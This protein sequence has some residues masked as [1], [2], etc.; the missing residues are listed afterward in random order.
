MAPPSHHSTATPRLGGAGPIALRYPR[1]ALPA[2]AR[3]RLGLRAAVAA[4]LALAGL[5]L[6]LPSTPT[7]DPWAWLIWGREI[8][9]GHL[10]TLTGPSWKPLPVLVTT[11]FSV[12]GAA[13]P[14]LW[15]VVARAGALLSLVLAFRVGRRLGGTLAGAV[16]A[17]AL[18]LVHFYARAAALGDSEGLLV[19]SGLLAVE[20]HLRGRRR[21]A[22]LAL[23]AMG[24]LRPEAWLFLGVYGLWLWRVEPARRPLIAGLAV[25]LPA[26][27]LGPELWGSGNALRASS[28]AQEIVPGSPAA[29]EHPLEALLERALPAVLLPVGVAAAGALAHAVWTRRSRAGSPAVLGL[30]AV[31]LAWYAEVAVMTQVGYSGN[32]RYLMAPSAI[33]CVL[34]GIGF[35]ALVATTGARWGRRAGWAL[36]V[37]LLAVTAPYA[38]SEANQ[39]RVDGLA[40]AAEARLNDALSR[41][42]DLAGGRTGVLSCGR[43]TTGNLQVTPLAWDL[44]VNIDR[45]GYVAPRRAVAFVARPARDGTGAPV[46]RAGGGGFSLLGTV[47]AWHV[48]ARCGSPASREH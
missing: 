30:G 40:V 20:L 34:G 44:R 45:V 8:A 12:A 11:A 46:A 25:A 14:A 43:P 5:S 3:P 48:L 27:W 22:L 24:L 7:Y 13:A 9:S 1:I 4:C 21:D 10:S 38:A 47:G 32:M 15:L 28:R 35:G 19:A 41:A 29:S 23:F 18:L 39:L 31:A 17:L 2:L 33:V 42:V 6:L 16:A 37:V 36:A 26:L